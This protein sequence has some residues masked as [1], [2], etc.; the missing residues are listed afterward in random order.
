MNKYSKL[1]NIFTHNKS[2]LSRSQNPNSPS[3]YESKEIRSFN[4]RELRRRNFSVTIGNVLREPETQEN[5]SVRAR[6]KKPHVRL[7]NAQYNDSANSISKFI[8]R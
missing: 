8:G 2:Q 3:R 6:C 5:L 1:A 7:S 4:K